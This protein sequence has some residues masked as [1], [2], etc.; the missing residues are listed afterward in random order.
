MILVSL[1]FSFF[2]ILPPKLRCNSSV[3]SASCHAYQALRKRYAMLILLLCSAL[4]CACLLVHLEK[5]SL[6]TQVQLMRMVSSEVCL[7]GKLVASSFVPI[8]R[9]RC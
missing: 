4:H 1:A 8:L 5:P 2:E 3:L 6:L 7:L 9:P